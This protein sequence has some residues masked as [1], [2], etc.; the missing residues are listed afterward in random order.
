MY[1]KVKYVLNSYKMVHIQ[2]LLFKMCLKILDQFIWPVRVVFHDKRSWLVLNHVFLQSALNP[3]CVIRN[4]IMTKFKAVDSRITSFS[5]ISLSLSTSNVFRPPPPFKKLISPGFTPAITRKHPQQPRPY[6]LSGTLAAK[7]V[8]R[9][10][11]S[12]FFALTHRIG[13]GLCVCTVA[14]YSFLR[15]P[16]PLQHPKTR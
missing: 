2:L 8:V 10:P 11:N 4:G 6:L 3:F 14:V 13:D 7:V 1:K 9:R 15:D 5:F 12:C 16:P